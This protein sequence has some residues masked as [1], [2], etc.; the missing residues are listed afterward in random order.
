[1][2]SPDKLKKKNV[3][4]SP[5]CNSQLINRFRHWISITAD[6]TQKKE[7]IRY[8]LLLLERHITPCSL[9]LRVK[10]QSDPGSGLSC[11]FSEKRREKH[12]LLSHE[13]EIDNNLDCQKLYR[14]N[15]YLQVK[16]YLQQLYPKEKQGIEGKPFN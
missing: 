5:L 12:I 7:K 3:R 15:V 11:H 13:Y 10:H 2:H 4:L 9:S 16:S 6:I 1:M 14:S 8:F